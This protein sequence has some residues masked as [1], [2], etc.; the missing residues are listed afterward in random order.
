MVSAKGSV[1][2]RLEQW[3]Q[4]VHY[5][6][7]LAWRR[8]DYIILREAENAQRAN[9]HFRFGRD[10]IGAPKDGNFKQDDWVW[11]SGFYAEARLDCSFLWGLPLGPS[12]A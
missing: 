3:H 9:V 10:R 4:P 11:V 7:T 1:Y 2:V 5:R 8:V 6:Y 12:I